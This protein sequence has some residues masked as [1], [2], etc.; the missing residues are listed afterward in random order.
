M[1]FRNVVLNVGI[2]CVF[3]A[4]TNIG[5]LTAEYAEMLWGAAER[6]FDF[7]KNSVLS[8][9]AVNMEARLNNYVWM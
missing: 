1:R 3:L 5:K 8:V 7:C 4:P 9:S 2:N 6:R